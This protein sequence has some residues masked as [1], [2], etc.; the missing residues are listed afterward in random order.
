MS[1]DTRKYGEV[2]PIYSAVVEGPKK[3]I[4]CGKRKINNITTEVTDNEFC[5]IYKGIKKENVEKMNEV[6]N[7]V[8]IDENS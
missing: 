1:N 4:I 2:T 7:K 6:L 5:T 3:Q 8:K